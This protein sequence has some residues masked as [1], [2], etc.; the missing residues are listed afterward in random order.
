ML[1][2]ISISHT[3]LSVKGE[4]KLAPELD[5]V[6]NQ[7][8]HTEKLFAINQKPQIS[9]YTFK[10]VC[11]YTFHRLSQTSKIYLEWS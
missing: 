2:W 4:I 8:M 11:R 10:P 9:V 1:L 6:S 5:L 3:F 7:P